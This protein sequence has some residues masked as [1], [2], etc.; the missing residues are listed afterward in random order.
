MAHDSLPLLSLQRALALAP[1]R[2]AVGRGGPRACLPIEP[3]MPL[4]AGTGLDRRTFLVRSAGL[5]LSASTAEQARASDLLDEGSR[6]RRPRPR[7]AACSSPSS[8]RAGPT[9]CP[10]LFPDGDSRYRRPPPDARPS[11]RSRQTPFSEMT[12]ACAGIRPRRRSP[13]STPRAKSR[14]CPRSATQIRTS[15]TSPLGTT[16]RWARRARPP[17]GL[18]RPL[19]RP[20]RQLRQPAPG[21][22]ARLVSSSRRWPRGVCRWRRSRVRT[23]TTSGPAESGARSKPGC[24]PTIGTLGAVQPRVAIAALRAAGEGRHPGRPRFESGC[25]AASTRPHA[26]SPTRTSDD[27]FPR[28]PCRARGDDRRR[29]PTPLCRLRAP[30]AYDTH[31]DQVVELEDGLSR[32]R[33]EPAGLPARPRG[34]R[35]RRPRRDA[36]LVGVRSPRRGERLGHRP[37]SRR[38]RPS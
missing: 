28:R 26:R 25:S 10:I 8:S 27:E 22:L 32:H 18:D 31:D 7:P 12:R 6:A 9:R 3:G 17:N 20:R 19:P 36:G 38:A 1:L 33:R 14:R 13:R 37:R 24:C 23:D 16:G 15:R 30:G 34:A 35:P 21:P 11:A 5:F 4:P 2:R 29:S